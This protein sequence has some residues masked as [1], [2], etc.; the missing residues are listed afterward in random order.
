MT[1][2][3]ESGNALVYAKPKM[4]IAL[5]GISCLFNHAGKKDVRCVGRVEFL[6]VGTKKIGVEAGH[7]GVYHK[8]G[9][10]PVLFSPGVEGK[11]LAIRCVEKLFYLGVQGLNVGWQGISGQKLAPQAPVGRSEDPSFFHPQAG[12]I[13]CGN[14]C[15]TFWNGFCQI[16]KVVLIPLGR[17]PGKALGQRWR[18]NPYV[19]C[20]AAGN[21]AFEGSVKFFFTARSTLK[22]KAYAQKPVP[23]GKEEIVALAKGPSVACPCH[24]GNGMFWHTPYPC[25]QFCVKGLVFEVAFGLECGQMCSFCGSI[26]KLSRMR[27]LCGIFF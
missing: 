18:S 19:P 24:E 21:G 9:R 10:K 5:S 23:V 12:T 22:R 3:L 27:Q 8:A 2:T 4:Q 15:K 25:I 1:E 6:R 14:A 17:V 13:G 16:K 26:H 20:P 7:E 11:D